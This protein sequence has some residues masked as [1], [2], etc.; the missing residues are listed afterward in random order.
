MDG[1]VGL[2]LGGWISGSCLSDDEILADLAKTFPA[3]FIGREIVRQRVRYFAVLR[4]DGEGPF[5]TLLTADL[6]ELVFE[7]LGWP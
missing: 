5:H 3:Y 1:R 4:K 7:L 6:E 2:D